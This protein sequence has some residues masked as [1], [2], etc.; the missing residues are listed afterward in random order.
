MIQILP[1]LKKQIEI[2]LK[3]TEIVSEIISIVIIVSIEYK[4]S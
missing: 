4:N 1:T 2:T 3:V